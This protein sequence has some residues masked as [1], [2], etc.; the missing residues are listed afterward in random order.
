[1][2]CKEK[3]KTKCKNVT[4]KLLQVKYL[5]SKSSQQEMVPI[6]VWYA[7]YTLLYTSLQVLHWIEI[8]CDCGGH[9]ITVD[10]FAGSR[11]QL[12]SFCDIILKASI[13]L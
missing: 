7:L 2:T 1:M 13:V 4:L 6:G 3:H 5:K 9:S 10:S 8:D 11:N 12:A